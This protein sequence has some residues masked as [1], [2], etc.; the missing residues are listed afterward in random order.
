MM[1]PTRDPKQSRKVMAAMDAVNAR[2]GR[3]TL[4]PLA[5]GIERSWGT[6]SSRLSPR[7]TTHAGE[8][9][10]ATAW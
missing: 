5:T 4:R 7:Y 6:R 8:M 9:L 10:E 1:F 3:G 2:Y